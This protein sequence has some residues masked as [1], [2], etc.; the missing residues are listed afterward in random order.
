MTR[1]PRVCVAVD[2]TPSARDVHV[3][4]NLF[5][6]AETIELRRAADAGAAALTLQQGVIV[7]RRSNRVVA[8]AE[9]LADATAVFCASDG[10][11]GGAGAAWRSVSLPRRRVDDLRWR[12]WNAAGVARPDPPRGVV[13]THDVDVVRP[14]S[15]RAARWQLRHRPGRH[16][17]LHPTWLSFVK[18]SSRG[19]VE[20]ALKGRF[21]DRALARWLALEQRLGVRSTW[22]F[23]QDA[24]DELDL[25]NPWYRLTDPVDVEGRTSTVAGFIRMLNEHGFEV[26]P[27]PGLHSHARLAAYR[28]ALEQVS[29]ILGVAVRS[30]R[31]HWVREA[32]ET[33][34]WQE[35]LGITCSL[36]AGVVG[37]DLGTS[38]PFLRWSSHMDRTLEVTVVPTIFMDDVMLTP[39]K[40]GHAPGQALAALRTM[41]D[42]ISADGGICAI[43]FHPD[44]WATLDKLRFYEQALTAISDRGLPVML[45]RDAAGRARSLVPDAVVT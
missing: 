45:A 33:A 26:G 5:L 17:S 43:S 4:R 9:D 18:G 40:T 28:Q 20:A 31:H 23:A 16:G 37:F 21:P 13:L 38:L 22:F 27:H 24:A 6:G 39:M 11:R 44:E 34:A 1:L 42:E 15:L 19:V 14:S 32:E 8:G 36:N 29:D 10:E 41:L 2:E 7:A 12:L 30:T 35:Q 25:R 3:L